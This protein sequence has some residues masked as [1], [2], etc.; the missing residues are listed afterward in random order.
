MAH[1][2]IGSSSSSMEGYAT[3]EEYKHRGRF[4][5]KK[6][7]RVN[8]TPQIQQPSYVIPPPPK[9]TPAKRRKTKIDEEPSPERRLKRYRDH[10]PQTIM[11]KYDRV[12]TQ[13]MFLVERSGRQNRALCEEFSVLGSTG[14]VYVV[15]VSMIS[16]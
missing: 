7:K 12:M 5:P 14:N 11:I 2:N 4:Q 3:I 9:S 13:R 8:P 16:T 15:N 6:R 1:P 10:P